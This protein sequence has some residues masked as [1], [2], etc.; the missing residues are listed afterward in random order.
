VTTILP[1]CNATTPSI[2]R[3]C[4]SFLTKVKGPDGTLTWK[5]D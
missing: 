2:L 5:P 1:K 3:F 4:F